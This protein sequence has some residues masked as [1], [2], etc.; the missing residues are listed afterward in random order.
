MKSQKELGTFIDVCM[1]QSIASFVAAIAGLVLN[2]IP[3]AFAGAMS[4]GIAVSVFSIFNRRLIEDYRQ[5]FCAECGE[6]E[7][8]SVFGDL[9]EW[10]IV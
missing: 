2:N 1:G 3:L 10:G 7:T 4:L 6:K 9:S 8:C 5:S